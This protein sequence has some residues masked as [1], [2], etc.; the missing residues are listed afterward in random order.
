[1]RGIADDYF[2]VW[3]GAASWL[4]NTAAAR[5]LSRQELVRGRIDGQDLDLL[6]PSNNSCFCGLGSFLTDL[7]DGPWQAQ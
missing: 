3:R 4:G 5:Q 6:Q 7:L 2:Q 1:M